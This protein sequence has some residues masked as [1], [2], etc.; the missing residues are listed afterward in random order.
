MMACVEVSEPL[1][2]YEE[3]YAV[4]VDDLRDD[5]DLTGKRSRFEED[6]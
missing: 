2:E 1:G 3:T 6:C 5:G 4:V